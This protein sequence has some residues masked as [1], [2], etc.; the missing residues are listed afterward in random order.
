MNDLIGILTS[1]Q[2]LANASV[3]RV[4]FLRLSMI[5]PKPA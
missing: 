3:Y 2:C 1:D 4:S 5:T